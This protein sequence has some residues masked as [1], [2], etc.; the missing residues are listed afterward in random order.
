M[1]SERAAQILLEARRLDPDSRA[2]YV[3]RSCAA[4][5]ELAREVNALLVAAEDSE[6]Y[7]SE[8]AGKVSLEALTD[9]D[10]PDLTDVVVGSWKLLRRIGRGGMGAV[11]LADRADEQ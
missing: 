11:Y 9:D 4:D 8:L 2:R 5:A 3:S 7:F 10:E 1:L 6:A